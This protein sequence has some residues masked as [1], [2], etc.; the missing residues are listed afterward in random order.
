MTRKRLL[1]CVTASGQNAS[2]LDFIEFVK[3]KRDP[4]FKT[5]TMCRSLDSGPLDSFAII[6]YEVSECRT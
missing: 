3:R 5:G 4:K 1:H 2:G 6:V